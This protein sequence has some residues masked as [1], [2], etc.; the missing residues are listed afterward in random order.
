MLPVFELGH[1][2]TR[3]GCELVENECFQI[4]ARQPELAGVQRRSRHDEARFSRA[5]RCLRKHT[6]ALQPVERRI[7]APNL[8]IGLGGFGMRHGFEGGFQHFARPSKIRLLGETPP[9][10]QRGG[11]KAWLKFQRSEAEAKRLIG[12]PLQHVS[13]LRRQQHGLQPARLGTRQH[14]AAGAALDSGDRRGPVAIEARIFQH[15]SACPWHSRGKGVRLL[16]MGAGS[17]GVIAPPCFDKKAAQAEH[18]CF[19]RLQHA[20]EG[21]FGIAAFA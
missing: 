1:Q 11:R 6:R 5:G 17:D 14:I 8:N 3:A 2:Q 9:R 16:R 15:R 19:G 18:P 13:R 20:G 4:F 12:R 10:N 7:A 21:G